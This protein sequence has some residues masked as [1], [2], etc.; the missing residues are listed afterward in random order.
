MSILM[1][2]NIK[3]TV[4]AIN[5]FSVNTNCI[6]FPFHFYVITLNVNYNFAIKFS[7]IPILTV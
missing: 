6:L 1:K 2:D 5:Y 4:N 3:C 7:F